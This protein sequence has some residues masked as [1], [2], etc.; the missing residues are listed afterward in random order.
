VAPETTRRLRQ[1]EKLFRPASEWESLQQRGRHVEIGEVLRRL[2][3]LILWM[4]AII[5]ASLL[6]VEIAR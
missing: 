5:A 3:T 2:V 6:V 1:R 4:L